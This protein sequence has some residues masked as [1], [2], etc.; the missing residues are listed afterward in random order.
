MELAFA[1]AALRERRICYLLENFKMFF[2]VLA[3]IFINGHE[4]SSRNNLL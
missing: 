2:T 3:L 4:T 1:Y